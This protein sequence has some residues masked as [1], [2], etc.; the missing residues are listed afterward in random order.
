MKK[1]NLL[2]K[3]VH[4]K[5]R[6]FRLI[7]KA[8][9]RLN[10]L[11]LV[12][13]SGVNDDVPLA[14]S[15][16]A[17]KTTLLNA[18][19]WGLY[20]CDTL[21]N[22][23]AN[24]AIHNGADRCSV[25]LILERG[26]ES[27][28]V[29]RTRVRTA[30]SGTPTVTLR[31]NDE[32]GIPDAVQK[33]VDAL[34]GRRELFLATHI[35]GY[36]ER[37]IP[38]ARIGDKEQKSL[39]DL[40]ISVEDLDD[41]LEHANEQYMELNT[42]IE[43]LRLR[44]EKAAGMAYQ[45]GVYTKSIDVVDHNI[46]ALQVELCE[47]REQLNEAQRAYTA[48]RNRTDEL[49]ASISPIEDAYTTKFHA[50]EAAK[51]EYRRVSAAYDEAS[52]STRTIHTT[53]TCPLCERPF[54]DDTAHETTTT[55]KLERAALD[56]KTARNDA[57]VKIERL[58]KELNVLTEHLAPQQ[59]EYTR[60]VHEVE[61]KRNAVQIL[62]L[63]VH[64][65]ESKITATKK[66]DASAKHTAHQHWMSI[67][68]IVDYYGSVLTDLEQERMDVDF[69]RTGFGRSG[70]RAHRLDLLTPQLNRY[71]AHFSDMLFGDGTF[72]AYSTQTRTKAGELR[73]KFSM[74]IYDVKGKP[75][76]TI[77][78]GQAQRRD[79]IHIFSMVCLASDHGKRTLDLL[80]FD[81]SFRTLDLM[82]AQQLTTL[83]RKMRSRAG[84]I[85]ILEHSEELASLCDR[86]LVVTR[87]G[88]GSTV[89]LDT[90]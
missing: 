83:L 21:G 2:W 50:L 86:R 47:F 33:Y 29:K 5:I 81:E 49:A 3:L 70:I 52:A 34:L 74:Q 45:A 16:M 73:D 39:F 37:Y 82:G 25:T 18:V 87:C 66:N 17:G 35:L 62:E 90:A 10:D 43:K 54:T 85:L 58:G 12:H 67:L 24:D 23:P 56:A 60:S 59:E 41:A 61:K 78:A 30:K 77:S 6:N 32:V 26:N 63:D 46:A 9:L 72:V 14:S 31:Y 51:R 11:G 20:E 28:T 89:E 44:R 88:G 7:Q 19:C 8:E 71:A 80:A 55:D 22:K 69:W 57:A 27:V 79:L 40:L 36:D 75:I 64:A 42:R 53:R 1:R 15:N 65:V 68:G 4:V 76:P 38:F 13:V 48:A 84:T